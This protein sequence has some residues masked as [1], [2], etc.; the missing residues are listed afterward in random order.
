MS[1]EPYT[2]QEPYT[3]QTE[4]ELT[5]RVVKAQGWED[6][7]IR[8]GVIAKEEAPSRNSLKVS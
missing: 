5:Y 6:L 4:R 8:S 3:V 2:I 1:K 7:S